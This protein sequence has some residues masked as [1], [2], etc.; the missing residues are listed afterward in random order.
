MRFHFT[1]LQL[2]ISLIV[3]CLLL[4]AYSAGYFI[5]S[6][7]PHYDQLHESHYL[8]PKYNLIN[9][10]LECDLADFSNDK[11]LD[12]LR[13]QISSYIQLSKA[14]RQLSQ[15]SVYYRDLN[16][17][18]WFG[19]DE[20]MLFSPASL[21]K[22][23]LLISYYKMAESDPSVLTKN[24]T[25]TLTYNPKEQNIEPTDTLEKGKSYT[26]DDLINRM[27]IYSDNLAYEL[28]LSTIDPN[29]LMATYHDLGID[30]SPALNDP[31]GDIIS[32]K[33]YAS[34]FRILYNSSYLSKEMSQ[35]ALKL[36]TQT[37]FDKGLIAKIP[38]TLTVAHK[39]GERQ[40]VAT[41]EKQ[42]HECGIVY[43]QKP[44]LIC[45][46][47]RGSNFTALQKTIQDISA[48]IYT[49]LQK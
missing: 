16:N 11:N 5:S 31:N 38:S 30:I 7:V 29:T 41:G 46:M 2:F 28:L 32:V 23:P 19:I 26:T 24:L 9:P 45:I 4:V 48:T 42:L 36:L 13:N 44:Y 37:K 27:I 49:N 12:P 14:S 10:L 18:P 43:S 15:V 17:G 20:N 39:F 34:F 21:I 40:Y 35:K 8:S 6:K 1:R 25:N 22:V 3:I 47:T 33:T